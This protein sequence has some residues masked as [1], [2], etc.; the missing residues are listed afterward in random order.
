MES[1]QVHIPGNHCWGCGTQNPQGLG[2]KSFWPVGSDPVVWYV[3]ASLEVT[4]LKPTPLGLPDDLLATITGSEGRKTM[5]TCS[6]SA[7]GAE[8]VRAQVLAVRVPSRWLL[9]GP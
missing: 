5:I 8:R 7:D 1:F 2:I 3:T 9:E 6:L 4:Y